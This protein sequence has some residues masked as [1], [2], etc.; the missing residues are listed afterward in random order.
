MVEMPNFSQA[1]SAWLFLK[2]DE[3]ARL[4]WPKAWFFPILLC[5]EIGV[6]RRRL[7]NYPKILREL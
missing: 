5:F 7:Q 4:Y 2:A 6:L 3:A 1:L